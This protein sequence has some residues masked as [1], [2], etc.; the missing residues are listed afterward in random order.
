ML[1][2]TTVGYIRGRRYLQE[3]KIIQSKK[4]IKVN[5]NEL[6]VKVRCQKWNGSK[7][8]N[9]KFIVSQPFIMLLL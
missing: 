4:R 7:R 1:R 5:T 3:I 8:S 6:E 9:N 2:N